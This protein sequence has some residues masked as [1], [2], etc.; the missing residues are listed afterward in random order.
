MII[1]V[2]D[3]YDSISIST[4]M[5]FSLGIFP[6][7]IKKEKNRKLSSS[8]I[9]CTYIIL[10]HLMILSF[11]LYMVIEIRDNPVLSG[12]LYNFNTLARLLILVVSL[13]GVLSTYVLFVLSYMYKD[14]VATFFNT[15]ATIDRKFYKMGYKVDHKK[16]FFGDALLSLAG[17]TFTLANLTME[18]WNIPYENLLPIPPSVLYGL[19][20]FPFTLIHHGETQFAVACLLLKRRF[21]MINRILQDLFGKKSINSPKAELCIQCCIKYHF[22]ICDACD[23]INQIYGFLIIVGSLIQFNTIVFAFCYCYYSVST[24]CYNF[25]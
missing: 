22:K 17:P 15:L 2:Q 1:Q 23:L 14:N 3:I 8:P 7:F 10:L 4:L 25:H 24:H 11:V 5:G 20:I 16:D 9:C 21:K 18:L 13:V 19:Y 6:T 12:K